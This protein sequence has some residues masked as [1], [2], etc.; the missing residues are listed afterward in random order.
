MNTHH[1]DAGLYHIR[2][3]FSFVAAEMQHSLEMRE[4]AWLAS[5]EVIKSLQLEM[6][7]RT[8]DLDT[9]VRC[10]VTDLSVFLPR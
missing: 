5:Q 7:Q 9:A 2:V 1:I 6:D 10:L 3:K 4:A 8:K